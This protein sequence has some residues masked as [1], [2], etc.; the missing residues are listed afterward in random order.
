MANKEESYQ[1]ML[2]GVYQSPDP[3]GTLR[4]ESTNKKNAV[5]VT[6]TAIQMKKNLINIQRDLREFK[7]Y[8]LEAINE[9]KNTYILE[10]HLILKRLGVN[11]E[12][13]SNSPLENKNAP[14]ISI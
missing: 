1:M 3:R 10:M 11:P 13:I 7:E 9:V 14:F 6:S 4:L 5:G 8:A 12:A 2:R